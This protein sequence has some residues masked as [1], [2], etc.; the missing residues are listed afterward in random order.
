VTPSAHLTGAYGLITGPVDLA[1]SVIKMVVS[2]DADFDAADMWLEP[3]IQLNS[4]PLSL[5]KNCLHED[6]VLLAASGDI[7][8]ICQ[9]TNPG[10]GFTVTDSSALRVGIRAVAKNFNAGGTVDG[11]FTIKSVSIAPAVPLATTDSNWNTVGSGASTLLSG[12]DLIVTPTVKDGGVAYLITGAP[13]F[14][15]ASFTFIINPDAAFKASTYDLQPFIQQNYGPSYSG[16]F[17]CG[18]VSS[19]LLAASADNIIT[20]SNIVGALWD[21]GEIRLMV[22]ATHQAMTPPALSG[23][24]TI[25]RAFRNLAP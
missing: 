6:D 3:F 24:F 10:A 9:Y 25:K 11:S 8:L 15:G 4:T 22:K 19:N 7:P 21:T 17:N 20:C 16:Y 13:S 1:G 14:N 5:F 23:T 2:V 18:Y 12:T